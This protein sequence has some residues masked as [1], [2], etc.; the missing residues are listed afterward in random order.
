MVPAYESRESVRS[1]IESCGFELPQGWWESRTTLSLTELRHWRSIAMQF[2][3]T[4]VFTADVEAFLPD[5]DYRLLQLALAMRPDAGAVIP[6]GGGLR[7][8]RWKR[9]GGG[10]RGGLRIVYYR[11]ATETTIYMLVIYRKTRQKDLT[12]KQLRTLRGL[13]K[14]NLK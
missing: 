2:I 13:V 10:K 6:G 12:R 11:R 14:E 4:P 1:A 3:E 7:K 5:D 8:L 9:P